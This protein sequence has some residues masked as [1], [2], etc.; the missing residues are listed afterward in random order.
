MKTNI[1]SLLAIAGLL[2]F[3]G[4]ASDDTA[5][6]DNDQ[7]LGTEGLTSFVEED[8]ATRTTGEYDGS[9]LNFYWTEGDRLWVNAGTATSPVLK[10]DSKNNISDLLVANPAIPTGVKRAAKASFAFTGTYTASSYPVR[11]TGKNG[12][13][14][15]VTINAQQYQS[16]PNDASH[17]GEDGDCGVANAQ[18]QSDGKYH[19]TLDHK[20][21]YL[22]FMPYTSQSVVSQ[23]SLVY[24]R[25][26][27][28]KAIAGQFNFN[29]NGID[30]TSRPTDAWAKSIL[31]MLNN[32]TIPKGTS[33]DPSKNAA[34]MVLAPGTYSTLTVEYTLRDKITHIDGTITKTYNNITLTAGKN[35]RV[36][37][38]LQVI[39]YS[40]W[41]N[42]Y[43]QWDA[44]APYWDGVTLPDVLENNTNYDSY[45]TRSANS[46]CSTANNGSG[47]ATNAANSCAIAPNVNELL[48]YQKHGDPRYESKNLWAFKGHLYVGGLW[49]KKQSVIYN[50]LK[51]AGY[52]QLTSQADMKEKYYSSSTDAA[53]SDYRISI[54]PLSDVSY[55]R[56]IPTNT[57]D[58][59][60][61]PA[62]GC[63]SNGTLMDIHE[64][65]IY[66]SSSGVPG[67][68]DTSY[69][70]ICLGPKLGIYD[71][72]VRNQGFLVRPFE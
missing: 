69:Y 26:T 66:W 15:K 21:A 7:E 56:D 71:W 59:F 47:V 38:D 29:D 35:R 25:V 12:V 52:N 39:D 58:Y 72:S 11:Y 64:E 55:S 1:L 57:T 65:L 41:L 44:K 51:A 37:T 60:F 32:F 23:A 43:C 20:A 19:F 30:L 70:L 54:L 50:D 61:L 48:Y 45:G 3:A 40:P 46:N 2:S 13:A 14:D 9:G 49:L 62:L 34:I 28:D 67:Y 63:F 16:V 53:G 42:Y 36:V 18:K 24:I 4:C 27:A 33:P 68:S 8:Q 10:Q 5:N 17:I 22:T 6:K 31:L